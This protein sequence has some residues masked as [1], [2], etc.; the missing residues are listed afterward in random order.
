[1]ILTLWH[2]RPF[3]DLKGKIRSLIHY[4]LRVWTLILIINYHS[5]IVRSEICTLFGLLVDLRKAHLLK[6]EIFGILW[7]FS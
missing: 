5:L 6:E 2:C 4:I 1:M 3:Y 7:C